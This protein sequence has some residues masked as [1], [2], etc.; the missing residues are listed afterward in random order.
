MRLLIWRILDWYS[1]QFNDCWGFPTTCVLDSRSNQEGICHAIHSHH[2]YLAFF[3]E[4][5]ANQISQRHPNFDKVLCALYIGILSIW[6]HSFSLKI[7]LWFFSFSLF[8]L[9]I[10]ALVR[11]RGRVNLPYILATLR[12]IDRDDVHHGT[13]LLDLPLFSFLGLCIC[14]ISRRRH[15]SGRL[16]Q[17]CFLQH[18]DISGNAP[19]HE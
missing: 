9:I 6:F 13:A 15:R 4:H 19:L 12:I 5:T 10:I 17:F 14:L 16:D 11:N 7:D 2:R 1:Q 18:S 8:F 3:P